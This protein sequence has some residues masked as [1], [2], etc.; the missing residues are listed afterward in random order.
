MGADLLQ[1]LSRNQGYLGV[2]AHAEKQAAEKA[3]IDRVRQQLIAD[4]V[5]GAAIEALKNLEGSVFYAAYPRSKP[6]IHSQY[7]YFPIP[8]FEIEIFFHKM[9]TDRGMEMGSELF[10]GKVDWQFGHPEVQ[11][12][13]GGDTPVDM[14]LPNNQE[15]NRRIRVG[16]IAAIPSGTN[17]ITHSAEEGGAYGHAHMFFVNEGNQRGSIYYDAVDMMRL[18]TLGFMD[19]P[20]GAAAAPFEDITGR[21]EVKA[22]SELLS[23][24]PDRERDLPSWLRSGWSQREA[25]RAVDYAEGTKRVVVSSPDREPKDFLEWGSGARRCHVNPLVAE[26]SGAITD[27]RFPAG[28]RRL[29]PH[30]EFWTVLSGQAV[31]KQSIAPFH[32]EWVELNVSEGHVMVASGGAHVQVPE[33]TGDFIVRRMAGSCASNCHYAMMEMKLREDGVPEQI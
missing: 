14:I 32:S 21:I 12:C 16:D 22:L 31:V 4:G 8:A 7:Y 2:L 25:M 5:D 13:I 23:V 19:V 27:C 26:Q 10:L 30:K 20:E 18:Q 29:H 11:Y 15:I 24:D 28:Y 33:A 1:L 3:E 6:L 17:L 9:F